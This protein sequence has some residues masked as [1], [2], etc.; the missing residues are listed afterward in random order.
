MIEFALE[1]SDWYLTFS[2]LPINIKYPVLTCILSFHSKV[3]VCLRYADLVSVLPTRVRVLA[4]PTPQFKKDTLTTRPP[5][6]LSY[7]EDAL[8]TMSLPEGYQF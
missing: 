8:R 6:R 4:W 5:A 1:D 3:T 2:T 7:A